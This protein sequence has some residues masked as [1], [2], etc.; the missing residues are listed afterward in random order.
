[1]F[2]SSKELEIKVKELEEKVK[3]LE[4]RPCLDFNALLP[5]ITMLMTPT[6][7][8]EIIEI[9]N[10]VH[11]LDK[12]LFLVENKSKCKKCDDRI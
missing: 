3:M 11:D 7:N 1:M 10:A 4:E 8:P 6:S 5:I 9:R 12:R 2:K